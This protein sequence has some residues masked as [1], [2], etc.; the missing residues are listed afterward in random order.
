[1]VILSFALCCSRTCVRLFIGAV[2]PAPHCV[3]RTGNRDANV[4]HEGCTAIPAASHP[5]LVVINISAE[6]L[7][8]I[9]IIFQ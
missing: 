6:D 1:M 8:E 9:G 4:S 3:D 2:P 7:I 5:S